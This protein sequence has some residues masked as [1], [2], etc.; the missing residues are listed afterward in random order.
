MYGVR[1]DLRYSIL[2]KASHNPLGME[3]QLGCIAIKG[4]NADTET[5]DGT[6]KGIGACPFGKKEKRPVTF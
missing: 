3:K 4:E 5:I 6:A 2:M 1:D